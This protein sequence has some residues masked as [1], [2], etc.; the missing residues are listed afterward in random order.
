MPY[1]SISLGV[2]VKRDQWGHKQNR[3]NQIVRKNGHSRK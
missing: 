1:Y 3:L 2:G